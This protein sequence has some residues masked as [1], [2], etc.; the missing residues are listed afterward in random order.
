MPARVIVSLILITIA[1]AGLTIGAAQII[2][3]PM[4]ML[5]LVFTAAALGVRLWMD[6][7]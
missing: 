3:L 4:A 7:K 6:R 2:G 1:A 5:G